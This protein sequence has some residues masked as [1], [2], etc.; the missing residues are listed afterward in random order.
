M[1]VLFSETVRAGRQ[2]VI[3]IKNNTSYTVSTVSE[4]WVGFFQSWNSERRSAI[5][6]KYCKEVTCL[7]WWV[8]SYLLRHRGVLLEVWLICTFSVS[9]ERPHI[10]MGQFSISWASRCDS[11]VA[12]EIWI[13]SFGRWLGINSFYSPE[14]FKVTTSAESEFSTAILSFHSFL[15]YLPLTPPPT[16]QSRT[17]AGF[18]CPGNQIC[19]LLAT[20]TLISGK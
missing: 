5:V 2:L 15:L 8:H 13:S 3:T 7:M 11:V 20:K 4:A 1:F 17:M 6:R 10:C 19:G 9:L 16:H 12:K 14:E 18:T